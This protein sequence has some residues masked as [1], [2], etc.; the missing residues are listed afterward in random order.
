MWKVCKVV[1]PRSSDLPF[2]L[3][4]LACRKSQLCRNS[5]S[6]VPCLSMSCLGNTAVISSIPTTY[7]NLL[8]RYGGGRKG[9]EIP[10]VLQ[11]GCNAGES[12]SRPLPPPPPHER[13]RPSQ[14]CN[15]GRKK[16][17]VALHVKADVTGMERNCAAKNT[18]ARETVV[19]A[20]SIPSSLGSKRKEPNSSHKIFPLG[21]KCTHARL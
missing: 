1:S 20:S 18:R 11:L 17:G 15:K 4:L 6:A 12:L 2:Q 14:A 16:G 19:F 3:L 5:R 13:A 8:P 21:Q 7:T 10:F 9:G